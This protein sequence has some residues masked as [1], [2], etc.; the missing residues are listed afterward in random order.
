MEK[1]ERAR[2]IKEKKFRVLD[3]TD[4]V[5]TCDCCGKT[6]LKSTFV[7]EMIETGEV[8]YYGSV[9]VTR[10]TGRRRIELSRMKDEYDAERLKQA[11]AEYKTRPE[12][13]AYDAKREEARKAGLF[14]V[15]FLNYCEAEREADKRVRNEIAAK[16]RIGAWSL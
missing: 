14:G 7:I 11:Q 9:C 4:S 15:A 13:A 5:N 6:N 10:N 8:F 3:T 1:S 2:S 12:K 16:F